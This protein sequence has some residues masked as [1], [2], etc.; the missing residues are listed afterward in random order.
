MKKALTI[1]LIILSFNFYSQ[2]NYQWYNNKGEKVDFK[3]VAESCLQKDITLFGELHDNQ[4]AHQFQL[5]MGRYFFDKMGSKLAVGSEMFER[6]QV[7][8]LEQY[9]KDGDVEKFKKSTELWSNF[10]TDYYPLLSYCQ[11]NKIPYYATNITRP[12]ANLVFKYG[13]DT[14]KTL[15]Q[16]IIEN[17]CPL[18]FPMDTTGSQFKELFKMGNEMG[19]KGLNFAAAQSVKDATM[20]WF[21]L[22]NFKE[23]SK[24]L[25][26]NG[27]FHSDFY[28]SICFYLKYYKPSITF[29]TISVVESKK[30]KNIKKENLAKADF[31]LVTVPTKREE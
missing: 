8:F 28:Q 23:N 17:L 5:E 27:S 4:I 24:F 18:P 3:L 19:G 9:L 10:Q 12:Y 14:L 6:H 16:S 7:E 15:K 21:I 1:L 20:A 25:H 29:A 13:Q 2:T 11:Q 26:L 31:I 22:Q 30:I